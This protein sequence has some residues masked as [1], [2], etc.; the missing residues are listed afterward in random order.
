MTHCLAFRV[1]RS[2]GECRNVVL[3]NPGRLMQ[4]TGT[5]LLTVE[6]RSVVGLWTPA[7]HGRSVLGL[8]Y[9]AAVPDDSC[10]QERCQGR[11]DIGSSCYSLL[12]RSFQAGCK[13]A[14]T[15][16]AGRSWCRRLTARDRSF[17][18][19]SGTDPDIYDRSQPSLPDRKSVS[20][21]SRQAQLGGRAGQHSIQSL[22]VSTVRTPRKGFQYFWFA[23]DQ[24][25]HLRL[26]LFQ[27]QIGEE[28]PCLLQS[29]A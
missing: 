10:Q 18:V 22:L 20:W 28:N 12:R 23:R 13:P 26:G 8:L 1:T 5:A 6:Q 7:K 9:L 21:P 16:L 11:V 27:Q 2:F 25:R 17:P 19:R 29:V 4:T 14:R 24:S 3:D 15:Q